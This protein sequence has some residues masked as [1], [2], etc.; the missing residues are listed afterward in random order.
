M[1]TFTARRRLAAGGISTLLGGALLISSASAPAFA[2]DA[3]GTSRASDTA[4]VVEKATGTGDIA[5]STAAADTPAAAT[6]TT[7]A[8]S[9]TVKAPQLASGSVTSTAG[10]GSSVSLDLPGTADSTGTKLGA[11][12][13][14]YLDAAASTDVAVQPTTDGGARTLVTLKDGKAPT[15][16]RFT[17]DLP[18][19]ATLSA[20]GAGGYEIL[21][22]LGDGGVITAGTI[23]APWAKDANG[24]PVP[25]RYRLEGST[26]VQ[27]IDT[28]SDT[29]FPVVADP[30]YTW[31]IVTGTAY[32]NRAETKKIATYGAM[33]G[34]AAGALPPP[35]N[36]LY[37]TNATLVTAKAV[38]ANSAKQ[39]LKIK[40][41]AGLFIPGAYKGGHCK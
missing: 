10:D 15:E 1:S 36:V 30:K 40:F 28:D 3:G 21:K 13:V 34:L 33:A 24:A 27:E 39:C 6:T 22:P 8:G 35:L 16:H 7:Q 17:F 11:G 37:T 38:S 9:V 41:A 4:A 23:E 20:D 12:T 18:A 14:V 26:L 31:G 25:T 5:P 19:H 32:M 2:T 29:A